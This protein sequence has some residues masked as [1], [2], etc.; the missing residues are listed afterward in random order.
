MTANTGSLGE[1]TTPNFLSELLKFNKTQQKEHVATAG[2]VTVFELF[3]QVLGSDIGNTSELNQL[4]EDALHRINELKDELDSTQIKTIQT[5]CVEKLSSV[6]AKTA[7]TLQKE[8][9]DFLNTTAA[10]DQNNVF[11]M[12]RYAHE[13]Q[14]TLL[15]QKCLDFIETAT[16]TTLSSTDFGAI[17][18]KISEQNNDADI[19][20]LNSYISHLI[21]VVGQDNVQIE[22]IP[23]SSV[24]I[25]TLTSFVNENC[26]YIHTLDL[27]IKE[28]N[29]EQ[30]K[31]LLR[32]CTNLNHLFITSNTIT[33]EGLHEINHLTS[34]RTLALLRC[35]ALT[36]LELTGLTNLQTLNFVD[37]EAFTTLNL[38]GLTGLQE[39]SL[40]VCWKLTTLTL[41]GLT[42]LHELDF[43]SSKDLKFL[44]LVGLTGL[45]ELSLDGCWVLTTLNLAGLTSLRTLDFEPD[46]YFLPLTSLF[47]TALTSLQTLNL[48]NCTNLTFLPNFDQFG[49]GMK[50]LR[51]IRLP[52]AYQNPKNLFLLRLWK[53]HAMSKTKKY[54]SGDLTQAEKDYTIQ[55]WRNEFV[56][57]SGASSSSSASQSSPDNLNKLFEIYDELKY[58][59]PTNP[60]PAL[61]WMQFA[62]LRLATLDESARQWVL[63]KIV[64]DK[65]ILDVVLDF[66]NPTVRYPI[67]EVIF[68]VAEDSSLRTN[69]DTK[70][71]TI[72]EGISGRHQNLKGIFPYLII[73]L[74]GRGVDVTLLEKLLKNLPKTLLGNRMKLGVVFTL[75]TNLYFLEELNGK[76]IDALIKAIYTQS[77]SQVKV[78][79]GNFLKRCSDISTLIGFEA[80]DKLKR[81]NLEIEEA[82]EEA[83]SEAVPVNVEN[84]AKKINETYAVWRNPFAIMAYASQVK[85]LDDSVLNGYLRDL[86]TATVENKF[87]EFRYD[88]ERVPDL[89]AIDLIDPNFIKEWKDASKF[90]CQEWNPSNSIQKVKFN[91]KAWLTEK[92]VHFKH[93]VNP[94]S[95]KYI[96]QF[97]EGDADQQKKIAQELTEEIRL[98]ENDQALR[99]QQHCIQLYRADSDDEKTKCLKSLS[100]QLK[101]REGYED[102]LNDI[103]A[104]LTSKVENKGGYVIYA[105]DHPSDL[106]NIGEMGGSCQNVFNASA[107]KNQGVLGSSSTGTFQLI[108]MKSAHGPSEKSVSRILIHAHPHG[109]EIAIYAERLYDDTKLQGVEMALLDYAK[110]YVE[111]LGTKSVLVYDGEFGGSYYG[112]LKS[113]HSGP[114]VYV[115][116]A[117]ERGIQRGDYT[118]PDTYRYSS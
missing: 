4:K 22:L 49:V 25:E 78:D 19:N 6:D 47:L 103:T 83:F 114:P 102:F 106:L 2:S 100:V 74:E 88:L 116:S 16:N 98:N 86:V 39:L 99:I 54:F 87:P 31:E 75:F 13:N 113:K 51:E 20:E 96:F 10:I 61:A 84:L 104:A 65:V 73:A 46:R 44:T 42:G 59:N 55:Y 92:L 41:V 38:T 7:P 33:G 56:S 32:N 15:F 117:E 57:T 8:V 111:S 60:P 18:I 43:G 79:G 69:L 63:D 50:C 72:T 118:I 70:E 48:E 26:K 24:S 109:D 101:R 53:F 30:I 82:V 35:P 52:R 95:T 115:D 34:L 14:S 29:D 40:D 89:K 27:T 80:F 76:Q 81:E 9:M 45:Q 93:V 67:A 62:L 107:G 91:S 110:K 112:Y 97:L 37:L 94:E 68:R 12:I 105:T 1:Q 36:S 28:V 5:L 77:L 108:V 66:H 90:P 17:S 3:S 71:K 64:H 58:T 11:E 21:A 23:G 85:S